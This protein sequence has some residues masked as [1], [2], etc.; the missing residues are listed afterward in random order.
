[1]QEGQ[2]AYRK[3]QLALNFVKK[4]LTWVYTF[5][6]RSQMEQNAKLSWIKC[7]ASS[8]HAVEKAKINSDNI[9]D[10][11]CGSDSDNDSSCGAELPK[12]RRSVCNVSLTTSDVS[13]VVNGYPG[14]PV[15]LRPF[16]FCF[17]KE[18][19]I[20]TWIKVGFMPMTGNAAL[21]PKVR[22]ELGGGGAPAESSKRMEKLV[23]D[24]KSASKELTEKGYNGKV[25]D[26]ELPVARNATLLAD[27]DAA[28]EPIVK[29]RLINKAGGLFKTGL[30]IANSRAVV[31]AAKQI[32]EE[33]RLKALDAAQKKKERQE[34]LQSEANL[35]FERWKADGRKMN[36]DG[37]PQL[38][39][40]DA[41]A[42]VRVLLPRLDVKKEMKMGSL[43]R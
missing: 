1:M 42:I 7:S 14:D 36:D 27:E 25:L 19:I 3:R 24:Y 2:V 5:F 29:N 9:A 41:L 21:D 23:E 20:K 34:S 4:W 33:D 40:M 31:Q 30:L 12:K 38:K 26:L 39:R 18:K 13:N 28:V 6:F 35:A 11:S 32:A 43:R 22:Y 16:D 17:T 37:S 8:S 10:T 15:D